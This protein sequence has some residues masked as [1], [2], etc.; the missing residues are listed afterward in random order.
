MSKSISFLSQKGGTG[1]TTLSILSATYLHTT[2]VGV[3]V[4]DADFPQHSFTR[5]RK[6][7]L[8]DLKE[9]RIIQKIKQG[10]NLSEDT[11]AEFSVTDAYSVISTTISATST[12]LKSL[13]ID[14]KLD[15]IFIDVPGTFNVDDMVDLVNELDLIIVPA[16]LEY[17][18]ITAA[19]ETMS[20][21]RKMNPK[22][23]LSLMW[24]KV[25]KQHK[26]AERQAYEDYFRQKQ[27]CYVFKYMLAETVKVSQLLNTLTAQPETIKS[28][29]EEAGQLL[30]A[31]E[32]S[33]LKTT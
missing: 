21:I 7:D 30:M 31:H 28:F 16:E 22:V 20:I 17:K 10:E 19:L 11:D 6:K 9:E 23:L 24:T 1:K 13:V 25:K 27:A 14:E 15:F 2:G 29:V 32:V 18:S 33:L 5:T 4:I 3:A 12:V 8:L 26:V